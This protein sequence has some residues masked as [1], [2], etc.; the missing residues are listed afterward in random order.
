MELIEAMTPM[1]VFEYKLPPSKSHMI[2]ELML[3]SKSKNETE[4]IFDGAPGEDI[5]SMSNCLQLMGVEIIMND[6]NWLVKPPKDGLTA[7]KVN[8]NCGNSG[9]VAKIMSVLAATFDSEI[10]IDG[11]SSLRKRSNIE[12][13]EVLREMGCEVS[14]NSFPCI[15]KGP[16]KVQKKIEVDV[17]K[18]SQPITALILSSSEFG[19]RMNIKLLG[20]E[21][22]KGYL[23]LTINLAKKWGFKGELRNNSIELINWN[24]KSPGSVKIPCEIS[25]YPM[26][27][28]LDRLHPNLQV[29]V[30]TDDPN[31]L[32]V[33]TLEKL[34]KK[35]SRGYERPEQ[36]ILNLVN[37]SDI[38]TPAAAL[39]AIS[40]GGKI[41]GAAHSKGKESDRIIK[42]CE[43][44]NAFSMNCESTKDGIILIGNNIPK[45][46]KKPIKT[47]MDHRLAMTA[48]ILGTSCGA[49]IDDIEIIKVT[50]P[51]FMDMIKRL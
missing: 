20:E 36:G 5:I 7:P 31:N 24:V 35:P 18:T 43:L 39:M 17:S 9:T 28:L 15:I 6:G 12:L 34:E 48:V 22:S 19:E 51:E 46:P 32:L 42:T 37:A 16:L 40:A 27:I 25:L 8:I 44:L 23:Q 41:V 21:V 47:H 38:I 1:G 49:E 50:H 26:A 4:I 45:K 10:T 30:D 13:A 14:G 2:R 3:A 33:S 29:K 11:D